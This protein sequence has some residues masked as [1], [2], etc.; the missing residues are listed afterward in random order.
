MPSWRFL[1]LGHGL[2]VARRKEQGLL[3]VSW[4]PSC[5]GFQGV[6]NGGAVGQDS[7]LLFLAPTH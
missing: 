6:V 4:G 5:S 7:W 2:G 1:S 3:E